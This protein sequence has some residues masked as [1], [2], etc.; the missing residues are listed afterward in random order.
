MISS[1]TFDV[2]TDDKLLFTKED[3]LHDYR[4]AQI[5]RQASLL[6]RKEVFM[7][8]GK[9]GILGDGKE[10]PQVALARI[11]KVG[12]F[13][14]GYYRD[15][16]WMLATQMAT[17]SQLFAQIYAHAD[18]RYEP[19]SASRMMNS[20]FSTRF[21]N[22]KGEWLN[23][24]EKTNSSADVSPTGS[25]MA[26]L[27]GLGLASKL[28]YEHAELAEQNHHLTR[29]GEEIVFASI[30]NGSIAEGIFFESLNACGVLRLPVIV[31]IWDD[32]YGISVHNEYQVAKQDITELLEGFRY[33]EKG[34]GYKIFKVKGWNYPDLVRA[35]RQA[36][37]WCRTQ[38]IPV[39][40]H[41]CQLTQPLGHSTSGSHER[42]KSA[43][44]LAWEAQH[45]CIQKMKEWILSEGFASEEEVQKIEEEAIS[46]V[47]I[48]RNAAWK[49][50]TEDVLSDQRK[51]V[52]VLEILA[53]RTDYRRDIVELRDE[54]NSIL[55]PGR[56]H[57]VAAMKKAVRLLR[58]EP[59]P[60]KKELYQW[61]ENIEKINKDKYNSF[62]YSQSALKV[63]QIKPIYDKRSPTVDGRL[64]LNACFDAAFQREPMLLALGEDVG[65]IGDV[66]KGMEGLQAKYGEWRI[67]DTGI[68]EATIA[69]QGL[70]LA[71]RGFR[72]I[73]EIQY[74]DYILYAL[75]TLSD[76]VA[77]LQYRTK[78][79]Q[80]APLIIRTRGHRLEG[81][82]HA[83]S[84]MSGLIGFLQGMYLCVP[85]N[86]TQAAGFYNTLLL[87]DEPAV[88]IECLNGYRLKERMP[89]N[90]GEFTVPLG[91][92]E[93][94]RTGDDV[95]I[96]TYGSMC[97]IV[98]DAVDELAKCDIH[99]EVIDVQTLIPFDR[100]H[101]IAESVRKT[102]RIIFADEDIP[103]GCTAYM[104][105]KVL[106]EQDVFR[107][108]D[109]KPLCITAQAHRTAYASDGDYFSKPNAES[110][111]EAIYGFMHETNPT[112]WRALYD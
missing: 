45:D 53:Q 70:G 23:L 98:L 44:R 101:L 22:E 102:N 10:L 12:D 37:F 73:A 82:W 58:N 66:N 88:V 111:F 85:R 18:E 17:V 96:V 27:V 41:V 43:E 72:P 93:I 31:S 57:A 86:M 89:K 13:R 87:A 100:Y 67:A 38:R 48:E 109:S 104:M 34:E 1:S 59:S 2:A 51:A 77:T 28:F 33:N 95:T 107:W 65:K 15:Q 63:P 39:I 21:L 29:K 84:P 24:S 61:L 71:M 14:A 90:I 3:V 74:L 78:G 35:Y 54:M 110:V 108:L 79:G 64:I 106:E 75:Q 9:F 50:F 7:G 19:S 4:I 5:S 76:D 60:L 99:C 36:E 83:G 92:P 32:E 97:R 47:K 11:F 49:A 105:Q 62:L 103:G 30:G 81:M 8:K 46:L 56:R 42:Y 40:V 16:T 55:F 68:R 69:G 80:K 112:K 6:A 94:L 20:H 91:V 25:Q 26:K 52:E